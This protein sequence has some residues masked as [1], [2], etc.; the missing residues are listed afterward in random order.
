MKKN[1]AG[2]GEGIEG[3]RKKKK[4]MKNKNTWW[5]KQWKT[6]TRGDLA[7]LQIGKDF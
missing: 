6:K 5:L 3:D 1:K 4:T 2:V 7:Y